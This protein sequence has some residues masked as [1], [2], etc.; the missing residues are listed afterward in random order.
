MTSHCGSVPLTKVTCHDRITCMA[1]GYRDQIVLGIDVGTTSTKTGAYGLD[2]SVLATG[3]VAT[4]L[5]RGASAIEQDP[6]ELL[7]SVHRSIAICMNRADRRPEAVAGLAVTGQMAGVMGIDAA[8]EPVTMY[9][10]WLDSRCAA[11]LGRLAAEH[12]DLLVAR[13]G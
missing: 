5:R 1:A 12:G 9:D 2:G 7:E 4:T 13:T 6:G 3:Q 11:Q 8:W 10:S